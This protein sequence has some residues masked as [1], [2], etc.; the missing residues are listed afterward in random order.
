MTSRQRVIA[1]N[2][3]TKY[4]KHVATY[5]SSKDS[6]M[7]YKSYYKDLFSSGKYSE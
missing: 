3:I 5:G 4:K 6:I 7:L 1:L 2:A